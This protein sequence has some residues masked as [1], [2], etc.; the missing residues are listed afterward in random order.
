MQI[1]NFSITQLEDQGVAFLDFSR[2]AD[3]ET[4]FEEHL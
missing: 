1:D 2:L 3:L 4:W